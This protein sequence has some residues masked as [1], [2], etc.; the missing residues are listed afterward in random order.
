MQRLYGDK[1]D[2]D[3]DGPGIAK[4]IR[5][6]IKAA[7]KAGELPEGVYSVRFRWA[8]HS[9]AIDVEAKHLPG[10]AVLNAERIRW[11]AQRGTMHD[12]PSQCCE[13]HNERGKGI[14]KTLE[15]IMWAYNHDGSDTQSDYWD[16][17]FYGHAKIA[18]EFE[19]AERERIVAGLPAGATADYVPERRPKPKPKPTTAELLDIPV[20][21][22]LGEIIVRGR[23][24][25][26]ERLDE[27][28]QNGRPI[29]RAYVLTS[30]RG[31][32]IVL[33]RHKGAN[34]WTTNA[35]CRKS[36]SPLAGAWFN[37]ADGTLTVG[38]LREP[39][40]RVVV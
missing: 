24:Y 40:L 14:L 26:I 34:M 27:Q 33:L 21:A 9:Y 25:T 12:L 20:V 18:W 23:P 37:D 11:D 30:K 19:K 36:S 35:D 28:A 5:Q 38:Y 1:Y 2:R 10:V 17:N 8:T 15:A 16:V 7:V 22:E 32:K 29:I 39:K 6:D 3:L 31:A 4:A 13:I